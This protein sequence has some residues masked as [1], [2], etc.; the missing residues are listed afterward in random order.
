MHSFA[1]NMLQVRNSANQLFLVMSKSAYDALDDKQINQLKSYN[2]LIVVP[3]PTIE[4]YGGGSVRCMMLE[5][6]GK[7]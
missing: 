5:V 2:E 7:P 3:V 6:F 1:G 4:K